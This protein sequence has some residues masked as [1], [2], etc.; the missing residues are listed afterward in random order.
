VPIAPPAVAS[1]PPATRPTP[2]L[3]SPP[4]PAPAAPAPPQTAAI[5]PDTTDRAERTRAA[6][7][8][9][10]AFQRRG[11]I[12]RPSGGALFNDRYEIHDVTDAQLVI[13]IHRA[14]SG[15]N[16]TV[17]GRTSRQRVQATFAKVDAKSSRFNKGGFT[18]ARNSIDLCFLSRDVSIGLAD[19]LVFP[20]ESYVCFEL[21][22]SSLDELAQ[23]R[24]ALELLSGKSLPPI[25]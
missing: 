2:A 6:Q 9:R 13:T 19:E 1:A 10:E 14:I 8:V 25:K 5:A 11:A 24:T 16:R 21:Q 15:G 23:V 20:P 3:V 22:A 7:L 17:D 4:A 12:M 18:G